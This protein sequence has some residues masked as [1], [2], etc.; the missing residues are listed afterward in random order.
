MKIVLSD[1]AEADFDSILE[2]TLGKWG[3]RQVLKYNRLIQEG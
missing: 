2:Y 1:L 3:E